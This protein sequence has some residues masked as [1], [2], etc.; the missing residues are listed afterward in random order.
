MDPSP[1]HLKVVRD[2]QRRGTATVAYL[3]D[4]QTFLSALRRRDPAATAALFDAHQAWVLKVL[5]RVLGVDA[6][7]RDVLQDVFVRALRGVHTVRDGRVIQPWLRQIAVCTARD[8]LRR[9]RR[10]RWLSFVA[11]EQL[12]EPAV[13]A[14]DSESR[15][16]LRAVYRVLDDFPLEERVAFTL[17]FLAGME[18]TEVAQVSKCS[19]ATV[20]RRL[21]RAE[22]RFASEAQ[23]EAV[24]RPWLEQGSRWRAP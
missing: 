16:A 21:S 4:E 6:E 7:L 13:A 23:R 11:P 17:R 8:C 1:T 10:R 2:G 14:T 12:D 22:Q 15:E 9:R 19:L 24:L 5:A 3:G 18:L 20:K